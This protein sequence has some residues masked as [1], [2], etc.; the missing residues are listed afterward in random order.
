[1]AINL[2]LRIKA[3]ICRRDHSSTQDS[4]DDLHD[5]IQGTKEDLEDQLDQVRQI[6]STIDASMRDSLQADQAQLQSCLESLERAQRIADTAHPQVTVRSNRTSQ[7]SRAIFGTDTPQPQFSLN[8]S[9]NDV[10]LGAIAAAGVHTPQTLQALL[11]DSRVPD[12]ALALQAL[13]TQ[14]QSAHDSTLEPLLQNLSVGSSGVNLSTSSRI[15]EDANPVGLIDA[16]TQ[17]V[18][19]VPEKVIKGDKARG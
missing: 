12:L 6:I 2:F 17:S 10:G 9:D 19:P 7:G 15:S 4:L 1:M 3:D 11:R 16:P 14:S 8:V 13:Q 5:S 18:D